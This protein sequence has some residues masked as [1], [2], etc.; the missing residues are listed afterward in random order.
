[1]F[2]KPQAVASFRLLRY[3]L[4][5]P[6]SWNPRNLSRRSLGVGGS[7]VRFLLVKVEHEYEH[8]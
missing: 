8:E 5:D 6:D 7:A 2:R 4:H 3:S 1:M